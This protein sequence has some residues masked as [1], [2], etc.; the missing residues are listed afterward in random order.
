MVFPVMLT[1][2]SYPSRLR[3][4]ETSFKKLALAQFIEYHQLSFQNK[5]PHPPFDHI[6]FPLQKMCLTCLLFICQ[7]SFNAYFIPVTFPKQRI[8]SQ[9]LQSL[10]IHLVLRSLTCLIGF[11]FVVRFSN[12]VYSKTISYAHFYLEL[13]A[14]LYCL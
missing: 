4:I 1:F 11:D 13:T 9:L 7:T 14:Q 3:V 10:A 2:L 5:T 12:K 6:S 8:P